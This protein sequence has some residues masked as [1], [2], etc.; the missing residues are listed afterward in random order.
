MLAEGGGIVTEGV[1]FL[2]ERVYAVQVQS[3]GTSECLFPTSLSNLICLKLQRVLV[4]AEAEVSHGNNGH[5]CK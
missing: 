5:L 4:D 1:Q 3:E 2:K